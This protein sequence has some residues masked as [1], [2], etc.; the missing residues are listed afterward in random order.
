MKAPE[1][2]SF[3]RRKGSLMHNEICMHHTESTVPYHVIYKAYITPRPT[4]QCFHPLS[5]C[6]VVSSP[7]L[8]LSIVAQGK[9]TPLLPQDHCYAVS[10]GNSPSLSP[11]C[12]CN[13]VTHAIVSC[14]SSASD[15]P[16]GVTVLHHHPRANALLLPSANDL[17]LLGRIVFGYCPSADASLSSRTTV[18]IPCSSVNDLLFLKAVIL[19]CHPG[20]RRLAVIQDNFS[21]PSLQSQ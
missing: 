13:T 4:I 19:G 17:L 10:Q 12:Q 9:C 21:Q 6:P 14:G 8:L 18:L 3:Y 2:C 16:L 11:Q 20:P 15:L 5:H 1:E 7:G